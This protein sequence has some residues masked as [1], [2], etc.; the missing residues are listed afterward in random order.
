MYLKSHVNLYFE[1]GSVLEGSKNLKDYPV[2][3]SKVRSYT[4]NYTN[5]SLIY[6]EDEE[7]ISIT[8]TGLIDGNGASFYVKL[9][10]NDEGLRKEDDFYFYK[11]RPYLIRMINCRRIIL[12]DISIINSPMWVQHYL[13]CEDL[14]IDGIKVNSRVNYNNDGIDIDGCQRVRISNCDII[15]GDDAIVLKSTLDVPCKDI[16]ITNCI[17]SS[18]CNAFKLGTET[19]GGFQNIVFSN[20]T[21]YN[22]KLAGITL[23]IV[24]GGTLERVSVTNI[25]MTDVATAVFIRLGN[26]ARPYNDTLPIPGM[27]RLSDIIIDNI[28]GTGIGKTGCSI[29]GIPGY[30][31]E[32]ITLSNINLAFEGGGTE[33]N[34]KSEVPE[35]PSE[36]PEHG[37]HGIL[38][39]YGFYCRHVKDLNFSNV[40]LRFENEDFRSAFVFDDAENIHLSGIK[41]STL[42]SAP[43]MQFSKVNNALVQSCISN[44]GTGTFL[45]LNGMENLHI[46]LTGNDLSYSKI[47]VSGGNSSSVFLE[48]NRMPPLYGL[49]DGPFVNCGLQYT[50]DRE[51]RIQSPAAIRTKRLEIIKAIWGT[52]ILPDRTD[53]I[54]TQGIKSPIGENTALARVD[55]IEIPALILQTESQVMDLAYLFVPVRKN[56]RLVILNPGHSCSLRDI[57]GTDYRIEETI[58][59]L[60]KSGFEVLAVFMPHVTETECNLDHCSIMN[61]VLSQGDHQATHGLRLFLEPE[62]VSLNYLLLKN[63]Y[64][65]INMVGLS[66]GGWTTNLLAAIDD[67]IKYS[68]S[69]AG[70]MPL[71]YRSDASMGDIEQYLPGLYRDIAGYPDL[72][73]LGAYGKGRKQVQI[74]NRRDDCCFGEKQ[75]DP[76]RSYD[77]D[78]KTYETSVRDKL[79][80]LNAEGQYYLVIDESAPNHQI[81]EETLNNV[82]LKELNA[83]SK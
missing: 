7:N 47:P 81:S 78:L 40:I 48:A 12:R 49:S 67:R 28:I 64:K 14:T 62:I 65:D 18:D 27:G 32:R 60:L 59:S 37:M 11:T 57:N 35:H 43:V 38:P 16:V 52:S 2:T 36:Y 39:A 13:R 15:S 44:K 74:L 10:D 25:T 82:I 29:V 58:N 51:I 23:Q 72:Y 56:N 53:V 26:R 1:A 80:I 30:M 77:K 69:V 70:S 19:N 63:K 6:A 83:A 76:D 17:L 68:F 61:S 55:R 73:V 21:I 5:K 79:K 24:D 3:I 34:A 33:E 50:D 75:H 41:A 42:A 54:V 22:T 4:D 31:A 20:S 8:G 45:H 71:Y 66:G 9:T 46:S